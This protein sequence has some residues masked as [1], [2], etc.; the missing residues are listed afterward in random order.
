M[1]L[2]IFATDQWLGQ[3]VFVMHKVIG[4][5]AF[6]T[7]VPIIDGFARLWARDF[8]DSSVVRMQIKLTT[9]A[10]DSLADF[11][12]QADDE[13]IFGRE[14]AGAP[15]AVHDLVDARVVIPMAAG[16]RSLN[17]SNSVA[18]TLFEAL[19][20]TGGLPHDSAMS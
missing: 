6:D 4:K 14:S 2:S 3:P 20:Q 10:A 17:L 11:H 18:V 5:P 16:A 8:H 12:F 19:R 1:K 15:Q 7:E 9:N 13:L